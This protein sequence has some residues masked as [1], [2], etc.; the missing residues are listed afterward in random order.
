MVALNKYGIE[1]WTGGCA[2]TGSDANGT[3]LQSRAT[4]CLRRPE[5]STIGAA[6]TEQSK[7]LPTRLIV[8][9]PKNPNKTGGLWCAKSVGQLARS[10][11]EARMHTNGLPERVAVT[12]AGAKNFK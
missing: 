12:R 7:E 4:E 11:R 6:K 5:C 9:V 3:E 8:R 10:G 1:V 2:W